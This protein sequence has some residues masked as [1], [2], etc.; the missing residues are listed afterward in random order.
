M[1]DIKKKR[2]KSVF[3]YTWPFYLISGVLIFF[4]LTFIFGIAHRT[5]GYK[6]L[7]LFVS[8]EV[9]DHK[10]L[11]D[12]LLLKYKDNDLKSVSTTSVDPNDGSYIT[13]LSV[14]GYN[15][16]DLLI[17]PVSKLDIINL[18]AFALDL[19]ANLIN[20]YY[21]GYTFYNYEGASYGIK[22]DKSKVE[23]YMSLPNEDCYLLLNAKSENI[24]EY[25]SSKV[26]ERDNA[27][28]VARDW[29]M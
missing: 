26:K 16:S 23:Q 27:L 10:K 9:Q 18:S 5:P 22:V 19:D 20:N 12:D 13:K 29:G 8:G 14:V 2:I 21:E 7:T 6:T 3:K 28:T 24:G 25:S 11:E 17:M 4:G 15:G 1:T